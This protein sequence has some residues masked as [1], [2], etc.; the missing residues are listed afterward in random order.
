MVPCAVNSP[1]PSRWAG[2]ASDQMTDPVFGDFG[3]VI[4]DGTRVVGS[5]ERRD[6]V[7]Q[8]VAQFDQHREHAVEGSVEEVQVF[9]SVHVLGLSFS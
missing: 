8:V 5:L 6:L 4:G 2:A 7:G 1:S 3:A 9:V